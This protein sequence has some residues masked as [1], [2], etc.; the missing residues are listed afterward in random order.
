VFG[1]TGTNETFAGSGD[2]LMIEGS[3]NSTFYSGSSNAEVFGGSGSD[4]YAFVN[5]QGGGNDLIVGFKAGTDH[6]SLQG[7]GA[8]GVAAAETQAAT[9]VG[10]NTV[11]NLSDGTQ[12]TLVGVSG[13]SS[14]SFV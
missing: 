2:M 10:G 11:I 13:L 12:I 3:G 4:L 7:Y 5:G 8:A 9:G 14:S 6:L 1:G